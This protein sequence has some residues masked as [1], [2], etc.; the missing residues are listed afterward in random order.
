MTHRQKD[1]E[2]PH[3]CATQRLYFLSSRSPHF[4]FWCCPVA[5]PDRVVLGTMATRFGVLHER[6]DLGTPASDHCLVCLQLLHPATVL[7]G[8]DIDADL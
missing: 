3:G 2:Y 7:S 6:G 5:D 8:D 4:L 1:L